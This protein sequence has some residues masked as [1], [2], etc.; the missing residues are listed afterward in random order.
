MLRPPRKKLIAAWNTDKRKR[1]NNV[2]EGESVLKASCWLWLAGQA[3][4]LG[5][6]NRR[7]G[8]STVVWARA[9]FKFQIT[10]AAG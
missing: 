1:P 5:K 2:I 4:T 10:A 9:F 3:D 8:K 7:F 6:P